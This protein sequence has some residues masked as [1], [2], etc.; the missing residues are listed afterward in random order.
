MPLTISNVSKN[1]L[2]ITNTSKQVGDGDT[3]DE[4]TYTW[5][6]ADKSTWDVQKLI[7]IKQSKNSLSIS[8]ASKT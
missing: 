4:A 6:Q 7:I 2:A 8:N 3:W 1:N 5:D